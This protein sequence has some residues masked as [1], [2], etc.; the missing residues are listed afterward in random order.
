[1]KNDLDHNIPRKDQS[2]KENGDMTTQHELL[3][4]KRGK[5]ERGKLITPAVEIEEHRIY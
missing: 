4:F 3:D 2:R 5:H 1:M